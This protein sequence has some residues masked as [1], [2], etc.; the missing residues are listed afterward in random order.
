VLSAGALI[1]TPSAVSATA[2]DSVAGA[3]N[4]AHVAACSASCP[5]LVFIQGPSP[6][7]IEFKAQVPSD[8]KYVPYEETCFRSPNGLCDA[9]LDDSAANISVRGI[10]SANSYFRGWHPG[11]AKCQ[12]GSSG[13]T[14]LLPG[15]GAATLCALFTPKSDSPVP[16]TICPPPNIQLFKKGDGA[17]TVE[18]TGSSGATATC[19]SSLTSCY[20]T[21][22]SSFETVR[23]AASATNGTFVRWDGQCTRIEPNVCEVTLSASTLVCPVFSVN[24]VPEETGCPGAGPGRQPPPSLPP[25]TRITAGPSATR[26]TL[27]RRATFRFASTKPASR[28]VCRLDAR[29]WLPCRAPKTYTRLKPGVHVFRVRAIDSSG[30]LDPTPAVRRWRIKR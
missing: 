17:G 15:G 29:P 22:W 26:T 5:I 14:C 16:P 1:L 4:K 3:G 7:T 13:E 9:L 28:F 6:G 18:A 8:G 21:H 12:P 23:L 11:G 2:G 30:K 19:P 10:N 27:S 25:N 20:W 24:V